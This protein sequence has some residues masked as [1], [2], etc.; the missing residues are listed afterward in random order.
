LDTVTCTPPDVFASFG[1]TATMRVAE[2]KTTGN[3]L[4][5]S[6]NLAFDPKPEPMAWMASPGDKGTPNRL[7]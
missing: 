6:S 3:G 7:A 2:A 4:P 5:S 1:K